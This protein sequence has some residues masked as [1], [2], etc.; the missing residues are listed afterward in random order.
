MSMNFN[1]VKPFGFNV[2]PDLKNGGQQAA[3][4]VEKAIGNMWEPVLEYLAS[5]ENVFSGDVQKEINKINVQTMQLGMIVN[6]S[7]DKKTLDTKY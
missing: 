3:K 5:N 1:N 2:M 7:G 6:G 4:S